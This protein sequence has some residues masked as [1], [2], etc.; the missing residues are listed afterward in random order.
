M[1]TKW[2]N[3]KFLTQLVYVNDVLLVYGDDLNMIEA[4]KDYLSNTFKIKDLGIAKY[5]LGLEL[6]RSSTGINL[7]RR[8]YT[9][10]LLKESG[11]L[12]S[13]HVPTPI[14]SI[15]R[16]T[17]KGE[18]LIDISTYRGLIGKLIYLMATKPDISFTVQQLS[19]YM[20]KPI[21]TYLKIVHRVL[22]YLKG[23]PGQGI[24][25]HYCKSTQLCAFFIQ[26]GLPTKKRGNQLLACAFILV[27][28]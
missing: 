26:I 9:I 22:W 10:D 23:S 12:Y 2:L 5:F 19:Q 28:P 21:K 4:T 27:I 17:S 14:V 25:L 6:A 24:F 8:K 15:V 7:S 11:F 20:S 13:K 16:L 18:P 1:F 3:G